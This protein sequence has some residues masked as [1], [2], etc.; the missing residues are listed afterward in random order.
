[1]Y[2]VFFYGFSNLHLKNAVPDLT[3]ESTNPDSSS[4]IPD[5][6]SENRTSPY[7]CFYVSIL[8]RKKCVNLDFQK[9]N[10]STKKLH[11]QKKDIPLKYV[12]TTPH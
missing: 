1:M 6:R 8:R 11:E 10:P 9:S 3:L 5:L 2:T 4:T 12:L 7:Y